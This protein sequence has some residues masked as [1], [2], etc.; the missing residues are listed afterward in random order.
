MRRLIFIFLLLLL[1]C[2][3]KSAQTVSIM[4]YYDASCSGLCDGIATFSISG[5]TGPYSVSITNTAC[6][7]PTTSQFASNTY[8]I[9]NLC[10]CS[11]LYTFNFFDV[12]NSLIGTQSVRILTSPPLSVF[13]YNSAISCSGA[14]N[15]SATVSAFSGTSPYTYTWFPSGTNGTVSSS[16]CAGNYTIVAKDVF[17]CM[18]S[19]ALIINNPSN[20]CVGIEEYYLHSEI[21][22]YPNPV[23]NFLLISN[24]RYFEKGAEIE[25]TD[26]LGQAV[27]KL[28]YNKEINVSML[29][30][31]CYTLKITT[32]NQQ[33]FHSKFIKE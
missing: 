3:K 25:I 33:V 7:T 13:A 10:P 11:A 22:V 28:P 15:A 6:S 18:G 29:S 12:N 23:S 17:G 21:S 9:S 30:G 24:E 27:L 32:S 19:T 20:P 8:T 14:C 4:S 2:E 16:L 1:Y 26:C 31:G 5:A